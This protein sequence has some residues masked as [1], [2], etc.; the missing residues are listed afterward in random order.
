MARERL[1]TAAAW[2]WAA[3]VA[4]GGLAD[5]SGSFRLQSAADVLFA[6]GIVPLS[7]QLGLAR[8]AQGPAIDRTRDPFFPV[9]ARAAYALLAL[10]AIIGAAAGAADLSGATAHTLWLDARRHLLTIGFLLTLIATMAGRLAP[11]FA[12]R[13]LALPGLRTFAVLGFAGSAL[14]RAL[15]GVAGQWGPAALLWASALSGPLAAAALFALAA[16]IAATL[17]GGRR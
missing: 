13:P 8:T 3:S 11:G 12:G 7:L 4:L 17:F 14:L 10:A 15:E 2:A 6:A 16:S 9:G 5:V 1:F